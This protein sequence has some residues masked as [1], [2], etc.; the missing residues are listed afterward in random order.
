[1]ELVRSNY[2]SSGVSAMRY[3]IFCALTCGVSINVN[4]IQHANRSLI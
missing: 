4:T 2:Q 1:M 3:V